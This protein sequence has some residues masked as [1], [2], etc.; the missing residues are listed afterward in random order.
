M[1]YREAEDAAKEEFELLSLDT[2]K[3]IG[4]IK[5]VNAYYYTVT[6]YLKRS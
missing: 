5:D 2:Y 4:D 3:E 1:N 6:T